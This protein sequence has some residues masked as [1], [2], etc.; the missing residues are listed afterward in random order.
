MEPKPEIITEEIEIDF[1]NILKSITRIKKDIALLQQ[2]LRLLDKNVKLK[3]KQLKSK[4]KKVDRPPS[5]FAKPMKISNDLCTFLNA[6]EGTELARTDV[7]KALIKYIEHNHL[8]DVLNKKVINPDIKLKYLLGL[9][10]DD[11]PLITYFNIQK[12]MNRHFIYT[13]LHQKTHEYEI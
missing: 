12:Y 6:D 13:K 9:G 7:T 5:G 10:D 4:K 11:I 8:Q 1:V 3:N 2:N